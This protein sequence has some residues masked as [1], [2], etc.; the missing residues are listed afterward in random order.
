MSGLIDPHARKIDYMRISI[1]DR[2]NL[3]CRYCMPEQGVKHL[4]HEEI[5]SYEEILRL[6]RIS[7]TLGVKKIRIT[8][9]EPLTRRGL[10]HFIKELH[11]LSGVEDITLTTNGILLAQSA[12]DLADAGITR[13]NI[14]LDTLNSVKYSYITRRGLLPEVLK[15][16]DASREAG[17]SPIKINCVAI[18]GFND[19]EILDF[20]NLTLKNPFHVRFIE[21]MPLGDN[22]YWSTDKGLHTP[23][24]KD[25][26]TQVH[27]LNPVRSNENQ[28]GP[29]RRFKIPGSAGEIGF[30]SALSDHF[31]DT[32][33]RVRLT[34]DGRLRNCLFSDQEVDIKKVLRSGA[35]DKEIEKVIKESIK[36]KPSGHRLYE[37][38]SHK[39]KRSMWNI[40]G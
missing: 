38:A 4:P 5:L 15:G 40:G 16:I 13:I 39:C 10:I 6:A 9:G 33:N 18:K 32:C 23:E 21:F 8:G 26:I 27:Q 20:A 37:D 34:P 28:N 30:I 22:D 1:T 3:R 2:C 19:E 12:G 7:V 29:A 25:V 36:T 35:G 24:I 14:S 17:L 31:C 11:G